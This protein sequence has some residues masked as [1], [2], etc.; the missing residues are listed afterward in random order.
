[1][2]TLLIV[3]LENTPYKYS[4]TLNSLMERSNREADLLIINRGPEALTFDKDFLHTLGLY[5]K[6]IMLKEYLDERPL[7]W[8]YNGVITAFTH[9]DRYVF[10]G[11]SC[12]PAHDFLHQLDSHYSTDTDLQ[13]TEV[14]GRQP[15]PPASERTNAPGKADYPAWPDNADFSISTS[16]I[17]Y[18]SLIEK[19]LS[20]SME[21]FDNRFAL[22]GVHENLLM[23]IRL[24]RQA[25]AEIVIRP[26]CAFSYSSVKNGQA[27]AVMTEPEWI[28]ASVLTSKYYA[29]SRLAAFCTIAKM[30][31]V[32]LVKC[33]LTNMRLIMKTYSAGKHPRC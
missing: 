11:D 15:H 25:G 10:F 13:F 27:Q 12:M 5:V 23:R 30:L 9:Y 20:Q 24:L 19:F 28:Y 1:M 33:R 29:K 4:L 14:P 3:V 8:I 7:S 6:S 17:I 21:L 26:T 18:R 32:Q 22:Y 16:L 31:L 2:H